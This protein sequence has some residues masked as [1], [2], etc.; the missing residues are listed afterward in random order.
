[1]LLM[2]RYGSVAITK[3]LSFAC[4][5]G[6]GFVA[7]AQ[8]WQCRRNKNSFFCVFVRERGCVAVAHI[9][10]CVCVLGV[11]VVVCVCAVRLHAHEVHLRSI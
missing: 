2:L 7:D 8:V 1:V 11:C 9:C 5:Y 3:T 4:L 6:K 10:V